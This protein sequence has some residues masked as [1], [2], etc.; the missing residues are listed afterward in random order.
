MEL[1]Y[2][3]FLASFAI[4]VIVQVYYLLLGFKYYFQAQ[5]DSGWKW[6]TKLFK[7]SLIQLVQLGLIWVFLPS[8]FRAVEELSSNPYF[9]SAPRVKPTSF[10]FKL[11]ENEP[12]G[13]VMYN[14]GWFY[15]ITVDNV[16]FNDSM[17]AW[18]LTFYDNT[19]I[20]ENVPPSGDTQADDKA[21][22]RLNS[23]AI[24]YYDPVVIGKETPS[25]LIP[26]GLSLKPGDYPEVVNNQAHTW[27]KVYFD[28][29]NTTRH[30]L[31]GNNI[32]LIHLSSLGTKQL[33]PWDETGEWI[34]RARASSNRIITLALL[35]QQ[36]GE[37][38][39][40]PRKAA[41]VKVQVELFHVKWVFLLPWLITGASVGGTAFIIRLFMKAKYGKVAT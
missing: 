32:V 1:I 20:Y 26:N 39:I 13:Y 17:I 16:S 19:T 31:L 38:I 37:K 23:K 11:N 5:H 3:I 12:T 27:R 15:T 28:R 10:A 24:A 35:C 4:L 18:K 30:T 29:V 14:P 22:Q 33:I 41:I 36:E 40:D 21:P 25:D 6:F 9:D 7:C 8:L 2:K 34:E